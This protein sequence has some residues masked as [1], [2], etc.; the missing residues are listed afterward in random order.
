MDLDINKPQPH[1][2]HDSRLKEILECDNWTCECGSQ[3]FREA[4]VLKKV[5]GVLVG[6]P[7]PYITAPIPVMVCNKCGRL[8][9]NTPNPDK[10]ITTHKEAEK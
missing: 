7:K 1:I 3:I 8:A 10:L 9:P 5:P 6:S 2:G 4:V